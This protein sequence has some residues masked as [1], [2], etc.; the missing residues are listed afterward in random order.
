MSSKVSSENQPAES[1]TA[2]IHTRPWAA[3]L[4][5]TGGILL[6]ALGMALSISFGA[7]DIKLG[8]VWQAI[9]NFNPDLTP[10][11][12]IWEIRL[13]R[14]LGGAM[15]GACFAVA[16]AIMQGMTRNPLAD[17]GLLGLNAGAGFALAICFAFFPG[18]PYMYIILYSFVG[19]GLG[20]LL[21]YG[22]GAASKSG[23]TPLR[24]VLA[25]AA[26][27]AML[28][29]LSEG[30]ALYFKIGQDLAFWTA[31]GVAGTKWSQL[32]VMFPWVLA[33]LIAGIII[34]RSITLL[35]LGEDIAV[36][37][38]QRTG[39]IKLVGL[40]VVL[41]LAGTAVSVVGA[42]GFVGLIIPHLTRKLVG[43]DY[44]W[45][46]PC[47]AVMGSL[48]LVFA[49]LAARMINPPYETPIGALVALIGVPF[50]LYLA[51]KER[52]TL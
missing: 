34:S 46:I 45:I 42:V 52:R 41:I 17:S 4:I 16:G 36:G 31:G 8:V 38:G 49:D 10:H 21:V 25:G 26:V 44:R 47:S 13:P 7:A 50:F 19:A 33:A 40:V 18:M 27:S 43:V 6:L 29:A 23:L 11:Q 14:I 39:L 3:T 12:I 24:L 5:L 51:R 28:S 20:V 15:V 30:I 9:F 32:E 37:L 35:S 2:K 22:F 1:P 48:L